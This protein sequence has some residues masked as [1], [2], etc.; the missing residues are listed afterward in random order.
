MKQFLAFFQKEWMELVRSGKF[1]ILMVLFLLFGVM[2]PAMAKLTPWIMEVASESLADTGLVVTEVTVDAMTSW[3]QFYKNISLVIIVFLLMVSGILTGEYQKKTLINMVTKG[4]DRWK[5]ILAKSAMLL[6]LWSLSYW[7]CYGI[8]YGYNAYYWDNGIASHVLFAAFC[9]YV[10][11]VW[12]V[13][14]IMLMSALFDSNIGV[15]LGTGC[16][17]G[18][19]YLVGMLS[20]IKEYLPTQLLSAGDLLSG[21]G[22]TGD[23]TVGIVVCAVGAVVNIA[24]AVLAFNRRNL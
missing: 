11:G 3:A 21:T 20:K 5:I 9:M 16:V 8:T 24:V 2:N 7:L 17:F 22:T 13:S 12:L 4:L 6:L 14:L 10:L 23:Y 1:A 18:I 15:L 19:S